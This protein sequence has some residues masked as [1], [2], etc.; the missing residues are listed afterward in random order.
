MTAP[1]TTAW[2]SVV[3]KHHA[4]LIKDQIRRGRAHTTQPQ[5]DP[6]VTQLA[7]DVLSRNDDPRR[8][9]IEQVLELTIDLARRGALEDAE[10]V[11]CLL[12]AIARHEY[13]TAHPER[14]GMSVSVRE[15][16]LAEEKAEGLCD[17]AEAA[18]A[19]E[20]TQSNYMRYL[21]ASAAHV[22]ARLLLDDS[23]RAE[24][25]RQREAMP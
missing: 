7:K 13:H 9:G 19:H 6:H 14:S 11:G 12:I 4:A 21:T 22:R 2:P 25:L 24:I 23:V 16:H 18:F 5:T 1:A 20:P 8:R 3:A 17:E 15:A 10:G